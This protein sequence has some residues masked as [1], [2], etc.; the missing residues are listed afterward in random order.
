[1]MLCTYI[2][3]A[4]KVG[5]L[6]QLKIHTQSYVS[7]LPR[8][9]LTAPSITH[10][11]WLLASSPRRPLVAIGYCT[12]VKESFQIEIPK[13]AQILQYHKALTL[14]ICFSLGKTLIPYISLQGLNLSWRSLD[15]STEIFL[16]LF[17]L[18]AQR[19]NCIS[20]FSNILHSTGTP[21]NSVLIRTLSAMDD[22]EPV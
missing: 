14:L 11:G 1:M 10:A 15:R 18:R 9:S 6:G 17:L 19:I 13:G 22:L 3:C 16:F 12:S 7:I 20:G 4:R 2:S 8:P 21:V 5:N